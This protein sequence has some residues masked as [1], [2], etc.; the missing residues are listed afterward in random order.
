MNEEKD[1]IYNSLTLFFD[2]FHLFLFHFLLS[3]RFTTLFSL[4][5]TEC[6]LI[7][8]GTLFLRISAVLPLVFYFFG[9]PDKVTH[10]NDR[11]VIQHRLAGKPAENLMLIGFEQFEVRTG[12]PV[13]NGHKVH[14]KASVVGGKGPRREI[15]LPAVLH[16][17]VE[18]QI[19]RASC[20]ERV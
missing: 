9:K 20:R 13:Q 6:R 15:I 17:D 2:L 5:E 19:G 11:S 7:A 4:K 1:Q 8:H 10:R 12:R 14:C 16:G 3:F 18:G